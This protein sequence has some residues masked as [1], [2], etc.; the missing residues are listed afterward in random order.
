MALVASKHVESSQ[1]GNLCPLHW[2]VDSLT[3]GP[4]GKPFTYFLRN[5]IILC[6]EEV[7][8]TV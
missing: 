6:L 7:S 1:Q 2:E 8:H 3:T 5:L 4:P